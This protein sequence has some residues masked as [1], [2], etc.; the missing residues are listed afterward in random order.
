MRLLG[1]V[2]LYHPSRSVIDNIRSYISEVDALLVID[3]SEPNLESSFLT[4]LEVEHASIHLISNP[5]NLGIATALNQA[6]SYA[7]ENGYS[8]LLTMDQD[9][10]FEKHSLSLLKIFAEN[11]GGL[12]IVA[13]F[14]K[15]P[16]SDQPKFTEEYSTL[17]MTMTS[18]NLLNLDAFKRCGPFD[19]K[20]FID[21]VD[22]EYCLRLRKSGYV[23]IRIN[24]A[25]LHHPL[26]DIIYYRFLFFRFKTTNHSATRR[27]Y[28]ARNRLYVM[29]K[30]VGFDFKFFRREL[31][32][33]V[34][35]FL[36]VIFLEREKR[37]KLI[38]IL[39]GTIHFLAGRFG[40]LKAPDHSSV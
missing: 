31:G 2:I 14:H 13:P 22:H 4:S 34:K 15:T 17:R 5:Q 21:S 30:Y 33:Y 9:S 40:P 29:F 39:K 25:M 32:Q 20:L 6:A 28:I 11:K 19:E 18:G 26:G 16:K 10:I 24:Q 12:G 1:T 3:N 37:K 7:I 38:G 23:I 35:D 36:R 27:Y 8:W